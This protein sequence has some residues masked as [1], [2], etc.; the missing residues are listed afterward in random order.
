MS[1][2][3]RFVKVGSSRPVGRRSASGGVRA[4]GVAQE[5]LLSVRFL[6]FGQPALSAHAEVPQRPRSRRVA[7]KADIK[8]EP[9]IHGASIHESHGLV[10]QWRREAHRLAGDASGL[11]QGVLIPGEAAHQNEMMSPVV[12]E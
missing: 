12:T 1:E 8:N 3:R 2:W 4:S 6:P 7:S 10:V 5:R 11:P 9:W